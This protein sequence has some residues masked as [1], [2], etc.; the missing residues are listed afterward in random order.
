MGR[1]PLIMLALCGASLAAA[2]KPAKQAPAEAPPSKGPPP[3][4]IDVKRP[5]SK[6]RA[7][8]LLKRDAPMPVL[9]DVRGDV[10]KRRDQELVR[11]YSR[12]AE[13]DVIAAVA[14]AEGDDALGE[15][16]E[17][18]RRKERRRFLALM[19]QLHE[20]ARGQVSVGQAP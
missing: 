15:R 6:L 12:M 7:D 20:L 14:A 1:T 2:Q 13:L 10:E 18:V 3:A 4:S 8:S 16:V 11:H 9:T 5:L 17:S 19:R